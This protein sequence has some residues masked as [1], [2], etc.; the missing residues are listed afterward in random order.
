M[1][2]GR[3]N[4]DRLDRPAPQAGCIDIGLRDDMRN[5]RAR[6]VNDRFCAENA[7]DPDRPKPRAAER[8][9]QKNPDHD[10]IHRQYAS[11]KLVKPQRRLMGKGNA[12]HD[13]E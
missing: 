10:E 9:S 8:Q 5:N 1:P 11:F 7:C 12:R 6:D 4:Q 13:T 3:C 2:P